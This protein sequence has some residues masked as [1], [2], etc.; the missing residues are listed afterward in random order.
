[1]I[2]FEYNPEN[3]SRLDLSP[4]GAWKFLENL[5]YEFFEVGAKGTLTR[6]TSPMPY[7]NV[8]AIPSAARAYDAL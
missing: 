2:F 8:V 3:T 6:S 5:G 1:M 4:K 7:R